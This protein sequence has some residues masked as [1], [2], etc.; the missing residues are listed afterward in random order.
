MDSKQRFMH[1]HVHKS[2]SVKATLVLTIVDVGD[3]Y[4]GVLYYSFLCMFE[5]L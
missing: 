1:R 3:G 4:R 5:M 2:I